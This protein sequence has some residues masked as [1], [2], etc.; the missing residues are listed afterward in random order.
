M[1]KK[2]RFK[3]EHFNTELSAKIDNY[4]FKNKFIVD[5]DKIFI[6]LTYK[7]INLEQYFKLLFG[8]RKEFNKLKLGEINLNNLELP[9]EEVIGESQNTNNFIYNAI[10]LDIKKVVLIKVG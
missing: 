3:L 4:K 5:S 9:F 2:D 1:N 10:I 6:N 7:E 8:R